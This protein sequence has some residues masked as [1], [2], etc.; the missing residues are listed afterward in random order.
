MWARHRRASL[1]AFE[2]LT[3]CHAFGQKKRRLGMIANARASLNIRLR[4][5]MYLL[6]MPPRQAGVGADARIA[7]ACI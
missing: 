7:I 5:M 1:L 2:T 6:S 3:K 4:P